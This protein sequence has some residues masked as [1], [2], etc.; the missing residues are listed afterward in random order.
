MDLRSYLKSIK[1]SI[2]AFGRENKIS[3]YSM[4]VYVKGK[5]PCPRMAWKIFNATHGKVGFN[6]LGYDEVPK[7]PL[8][9]F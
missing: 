2:R 7:N 5:K 8:K 4:M 6:D 1:K 9:D 3:H